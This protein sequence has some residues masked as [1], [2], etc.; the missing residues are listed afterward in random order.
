MFASMHTTSVE[1]DDLFVFDPA[2][3]A[4]TDLTALAAGDPP[5]GRDSLGFAAAAGRLYVY[6]GE[7]GYGE[8]GRAS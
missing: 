1:F 2:A 8:W 4:W 5:A 7:R 3:A 6:G